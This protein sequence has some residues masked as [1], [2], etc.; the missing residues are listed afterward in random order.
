MSVKYV[1]TLNKMIVKYVFKIF[2][3]SAKLKS[4]WIK[5]TFLMT[6]FNHA[7]IFFKLIDQSKLSDI[8]I[9]HNNCLG[10]MLIT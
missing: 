4:V 9:S 8:Y 3:D 5:I 7:M 1:Y 6:G 2:L 10:D